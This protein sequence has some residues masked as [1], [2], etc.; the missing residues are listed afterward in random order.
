MELIKKAINSN[1]MIELL[2][3][4]GDYCLENDSWASISAPID[5]TRVIPMIYKEYVETQDESVK[6]M[7]ESAIEN[8]LLGTAE[9]TY[10]GIAVLYFQTLRESS[11]RS[12]F[13]VD[14]EYLIQ[15]AKKGISKNKKDLRLIKK[16]AGA[17]S[18]NG[19]W[20]EVVRYKKLFLSKYSIDI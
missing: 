18:E 15:I 8:M 19:L 17:Q 20:S 4:K 5:W 11:N 3:G 16:W 10:C 7:Y 1:E 13:S 9:E 14:R 12:P 2:E 6:E